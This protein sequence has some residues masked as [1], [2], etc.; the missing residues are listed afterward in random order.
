MSS[1]H[2]RLGVTAASGHLGR[3]VVEALVR[4]VPG[5]S[6]VA[7]ARDITKLDD[8]A[9][10]G[11]EVRR[12]DYADPPSLDVAFAGIGRLLLISGNDLTPGVRASQHRNAVDAAKR[13]GVGLL[14]YTS[15]LHA[16]TTPLGLAGDHRSTEAMLRESGLPFVLLRNGWYTENYTAGLQ[17]AVTYGTHMGSGGT[18]RIAS[19]TRADFAEAAAHILASDD[20][21][22]GRIYELAGD[23]AWSL[24]DYAAEVSRQSGKPVT[25]TDLPQ[26]DYESALLKVGLPPLVAAM[27]ADSDAGVAKGAL[28]D[29]GHALSRLIGR[30]TTPMAETVREALAG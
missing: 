11:V 18:G 21:Q 29:D 5:M 17:A 8:L 3:L 13:G 26:S 10:Q 22:A 23:A 16:D 20:D 25:Y 19:A 12:A 27:L 6:I 7:M 28:E 15:I 30:P 9:A 24:A 1:T 2:P 4:L 14:A